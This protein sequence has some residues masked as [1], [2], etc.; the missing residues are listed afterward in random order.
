MLVGPPHR[1]HLPA[2]PHESEGLSGIYRYLHELHQALGV[3]MSAIV[4]N[5][6]GMLGIKGLSSSGNIARNFV[7]QSLQIGNQTSIGWT[8]TNIEVDASYMLFY[9]P[10]SA[11]GMVM[12]S[13]TQQ[14]TQALFTFNP[15]VPSGLTLNIMLV[16]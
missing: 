9:T 8:F 2:P 5:S 14:T 15:A 4:G 12:T 13:Y 7:K 1:P 6:V 10:S 16:R 3:G 11:T